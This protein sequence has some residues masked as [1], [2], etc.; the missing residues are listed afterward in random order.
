MNRVVP[1]TFD[2]L[3]VLLFAMVGR[4]SHG[5][6]LNLADTFVTFWPFAAALL[7]GWAVVALL[8]W[9]GSGV[10][11]TIIIWLVTVAG[12]MALRV[13]AGG[14]TSPTFVLVAAVTLG[15]FLSGRRLVAAVSRRRRTAE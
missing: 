8:G 15:L 7:V 4:S 5:R 10:R 11:E 6:S 13:A 1:I 2:L 14:T 12:G 9:D 3:A